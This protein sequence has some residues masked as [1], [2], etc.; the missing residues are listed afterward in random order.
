[1]ENCFFVVIVYDAMR[2]YNASMLEILL[3]NAL[4]GGDSGAWV[5]NNDN[6]SVCGH[7]LAWCER[8]SIAYICPADVLLEDMKRT[9]GASRVG[10]PGGIEETNKSSR[11]L[12]AAAPDAATAPGS[13]LRSSISNH[14]LPD[15]TRL[16]LG[17]GNM[18]SSRLNGSAVSP[19]MEIRRVFGGGMAR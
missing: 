2:N 1:M 8:N 3:T 6:G 16:G 7:V 12:I 18:L 9:L 11:R 4:V 17:G 15:I 19:R 14:G 10:L 13:A 5:I